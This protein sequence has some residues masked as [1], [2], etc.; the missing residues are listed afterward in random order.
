MILLAPVG[1]PQM[2]LKDAAKACG[3]AIST[4]SHRINTDPAWKRCAIMSPSG[5]RVWAVDIQKALAAGL[6]RYTTGDKP[7]FTAR[8]LVDQVKADPALRRELAAAILGVA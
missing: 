6:A 8:D 1:V 7:A 2:R 5:T 4:M 3:V